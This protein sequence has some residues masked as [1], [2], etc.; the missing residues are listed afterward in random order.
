MC[1]DRTIMVDGEAVTVTGDQWP[2]GQ[3]VGTHTKSFIVDEQ[4]YYV[5]SQNLYN[6][7]NA[8][9]GYIVDDQEEARKYLEEY[10]DKMWKYSFTQC[11][12]DKRYKFHADNFGQDTCWCSLCLKECGHR[13][14]GPPQPILT[15][16]S[17]LSYNFS[18]KECLSCQYK[19]GCC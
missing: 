17:C 8:E 6:C 18:C 11:P 16:L 5:G 14:W 4:C 13:I 12:L 3:P 7:N 10:W 9:W 19:C 1:K 2:S 15:C